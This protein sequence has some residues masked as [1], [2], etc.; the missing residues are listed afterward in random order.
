MR[1]LVIIIASV[2]ILA[3]FAGCLGEGDKEKKQKPPEMTLKQGTIQEMSGWIQEDGNEHAAQDFPLSLNNSNIVSIEITVM[4]EDS[5]G[6][7]AETDQGSDPD[8]ISVTVAG[9]NNTETKDGITPFSAIF[10]F[11]VQGGQEATDF[12]DGAW[13]VHIDAALG[14]GKP[15]F[16]FG[17]IIWIDQG[18]AYT[19]SGQYTYLVEEASM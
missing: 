6:E 19:I 8:S 10:E 5:D 18:V 7:H 1:K 15:R 12:L 3:A 16:F 14:G 13:S 9:G 17:F 11:T 4:V 2:L